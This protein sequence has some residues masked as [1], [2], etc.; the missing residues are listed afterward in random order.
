MCVY[1]SHSQ[2]KIR[3][4]AG[5][6]G[7]GKTWIFEHQ[8]VLR[9]RC[10][11]SDSAKYQKTDNWFKDYVSDIIKDANSGEYDLIF[12]STHKYVIDELCKRR[13]HFYCVYPHL[14]LKK[15]WIERL[16]RRADD[17]V[18]KI[19]SENYDSFI[20]DLQS[21]KS[22]FKIDIQ[23]IYNNQYLLD[24]LESKNIC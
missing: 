17:R 11:D 1:S 2:K 9:I 4:I 20:R 12:V 5:F 7:V 15:H 6:P 21:N 13:V 10:K 23:I 24:I 8:K 16:F 14:N 18:T 19:V 22:P 3:I